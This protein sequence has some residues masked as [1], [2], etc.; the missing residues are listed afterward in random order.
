MTTPLVP[1]FIADLFKDQLSKIHT[2]II[3]RICQ[4]YGLNEKEVREKI[5]LE[6]YKFQNNEIRIIQKKHDDKYGKKNGNAKCIAR[7]YDK[8]ERTLSQCTRSQRKECGCYCKSHY[9]MVRKNNLIFGTI[10][11]EIPQDIKGK[12]TRKLY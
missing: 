7:V 12:M 5:G 6:E 9:E 1:W 4:V 10:N 8:N 11:D 3:K 2:D